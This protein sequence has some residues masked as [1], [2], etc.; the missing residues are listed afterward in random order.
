MRKTIIISVLLMGGFVTVMAQQ[1]DKSQG[2]QSL[3]K[4]PSEKQASLSKPVKK[5]EQSEPALRLEAMPTTISRSQ[6][7]KKQPL[8]AKSK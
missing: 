5:V 8:N 2:K 4:Q 3:E 1:V 7:S 6:D